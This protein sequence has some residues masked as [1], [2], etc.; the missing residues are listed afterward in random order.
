M[1]LL[2]SIS[3]QSMMM[4]FVSTALSAKTGDEVLKTGLGG[5]TVRLSH[6]PNL[7]RTDARNLQNFRDSVHEAFDGK[8]TP[9]R[10]DQ[11]LD[12]VFGNGPAAKSLTARSVLKVV[13]RLEA[14]QTTPAA[15]TPP[16]PQAHQ[17]APAAA[18]VES[19]RP[20]AQDDAGPRLLATIRQEGEALAQKLLDD[21]G[22]K[23]P[24]AWKAELRA[25]LDGILQSPQTASPRDFALLSDPN[26]TPLDKA[27]ASRSLQNRM[28]E[29]MKKATK[30]SFVDAGVKDELA[31]FEDRAAG[32]GAELNRIGSHDMQQKVLSVLKDL[33]RAKVESDYRHG[34]SHVG[35]FADEMLQACEDKVAALRSFKGWDTLPAS[36]RRNFLLRALPASDG[37]SFAFTA[38][39][40]RRIPSLAKEFDSLATIMTDLAHTKG[41]VDEVVS[42]LEGLALQLEVVIKSEGDAFERDPAS[43][44]AYQGNTPGKAAGEVVTNSMLELFVSRNPRVAAQFALL[45]HAL[46]HAVLD[47]LSAQIGALT[48]GAAG[49]QPEVAE[50]V[51]FLSAA[52]G[53]FADCTP[54]LAEGCQTVMDTLSGH[55]PPTEIEQAMFRQA[56]PNGAHGAEARL[57]L[58]QTVVQTAEPA[59]ADLGQLNALLRARVPNADEIVAPFA[60][61][62][63]R[64]SPILPHDRQIQQLQE[65]L[66]L[67][68]AIL[69]NHEQ[70]CAD[71]HKEGSPFYFMSAAGREGQSQALR[72]LP[73]GLGGHG[74]AT[75]SADACALARLRQT[76]MRV[77]VMLSD[78]DT[79]VKLVAHVT[80][81]QYL[82]EE[83]KTQFLAAYAARQ[84]VPMDDDLLAAC[85]EG[86]NALLDE[87]EETRPDLIQKA[88]VPV[89]RGDG[90]KASYNPALADLLQTLEKA[91]VGL[92][93]ERAAR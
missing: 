22:A 43:T 3:E 38:D 27:C 71:M 62:K 24:D 20:P 36:V 8:L 91:V 90:P 23:R 33:F 2:S 29:L 53:F 6:T 34:F 80:R 42:G 30:D 44:T 59:V 47:K 37:E 41:L 12:G 21:I 28:E 60:L 79:V 5:H 64:G 39:A 67:A 26:A 1:G 92:V 25:T 54:L 9:A 82:K 61:Q 81:L 51:S 93:D 17:T 32:F 78:R 4:K 13:N 7:A 73:D 14:A 72:S 16:A 69:A 66:A 15:S 65:I 57:R 48:G 87:I 46:K 74:H 58:L 70:V 55:R 35:H 45:P 83:V 52:A 68:E 10:I 85:E 76:M 77:P 18:P 11:L 88:F 40:L 84:G 63:R 75:G 86:M 19:P 50:R 89:P 49:E 56:L 31:H